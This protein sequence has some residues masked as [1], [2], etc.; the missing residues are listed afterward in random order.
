MK[1]KLDMLE[2]VTNVMETINMEE[3][4]NNLNREIT[5]LKMINESQI[6]QRNA[7]LENVVSHEELGKD[8]EKELISRSSYLDS[9]LMNN[10]YLQLGHRDNNTVHMSQDIT[11]SIQLANA[12]ANGMGNESR[13]DANRLKNFSTRDRLDLQ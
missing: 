9:N 13:N 6:S 4:E 5:K 8:N 1:T 2:S 7:T 12:N 3:A 10:R 11:L